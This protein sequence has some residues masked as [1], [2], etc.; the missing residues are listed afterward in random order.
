M[1]G[2]ILK[3]G[4]EN[5]KGLDWVENSMALS[6]TLPAGRLQAAAM[7]WLKEGKQFIKGP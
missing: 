6:S 3:K 1:G 4:R 5:R 7:S 2:F